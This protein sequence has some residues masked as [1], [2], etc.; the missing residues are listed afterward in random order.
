MVDY[1]ADIRWRI[2]LV[3]YIFPVVLY[4]LVMVFVS[5]DDALSNVIFGSL[6]VVAFALSLALSRR[7]YLYSFDPLND[8]L[9]VSYYNVFLQRRVVQ[10]PA[11]EL[12]GIGWLQV[13]P[14]TQCPTLKV[15]VGNKWQ[16]FSI[17]SKGL[18]D[19][20]RLFFHAANVGIM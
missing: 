8:G 16:G 12:A 5:F 1:S 18:R 20:T 2:L 9:E 11:S 10:V 13:D 3:H 4:T 17:L 15:R 6:L 7:K 19:A 14:I